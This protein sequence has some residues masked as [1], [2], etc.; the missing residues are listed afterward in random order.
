MRRG[1]RAGRSRCRLVSALVAGGL[2]IVPTGCSDDG[3]PP[4]VAAQVGEEAIAASEIADL[5][6]RYLKT[7]S[8]QKLAEQF[9]EDELER[10]VL[11][12][13]IR[14]RLLEQTA[15]ELGVDEEADTES[16][17]SF[18]SMLFANEPYEEAYKAHGFSERDLITAERAGQLS[19]AIA[20]KVFPEVPVS[21]KELQALYQ[22]RR[23]QYNQSWEI[24]AHVAVLASS[25]AASEAVSK[26][27]NGEEFVRATADAGS[28]AASET[29]ISRTSPLPVFVIEQVERLQPGQLSDPIPV[30]DRWLLVLAKERREILAR[31]FEDARPELEA[32]L[33]DRKRLELFQEWFKQQVGDATVSVDGH[34]GR[35]DPVAG[36]VR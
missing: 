11:G 27:G 16:F 17:G 3:G 5:T 31:S 14:L 19:Q 13:E 30:R 8:G 36:L 2:L 35:W 1:G 9:G 10:L 7:A 32:F 21:E 34:Y 28:L 18:V 24:D 23:D 4:E 29:K 15:A 26:I 6:R 33:A 12:Y 22:E 20:E 25:A